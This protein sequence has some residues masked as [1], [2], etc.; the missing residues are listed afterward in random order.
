LKS[1]PK[2]QN[3]IFFCHHQNHDKKKVT[4]KTAR[5]PFFKKNRLLPTP[6]AATKKGISSG[7][8]TEQQEFREVISKSQ[9]LLS[10]LYYLK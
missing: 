4:T 8:T 6:I 3:Q 5:I 7:K 10:S 1:S 2:G 9:Q